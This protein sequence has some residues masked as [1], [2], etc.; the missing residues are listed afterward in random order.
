MSIDAD[1]DDDDDD[2]EDEDDDE[3]GTDEDR[4]NAFETTS[5]IETSVLTF[6]AVLPA[7]ANTDDIA[8]DL[9]NTRAARTPNAREAK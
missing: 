3:D 7:Y 9:M 5:A 6:A 8:P 4:A 1:D 2:I